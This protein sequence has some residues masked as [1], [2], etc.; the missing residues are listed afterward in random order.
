ME[1]G[2]KKIFIEH[3]TV[4]FTL[5]HQSCILVRGCKLLYTTSMGTTVVKLIIKNPINPSKKI[6]GEFLVD[7]GAHYTVLPASMVKRLGLKGAYEQK[8]F[9][10][11]GRVMKRVVA[12]ALVNFHGRELP[13]PVVLG[14][15]DDSALLGVT[16]LETFGLMLDPFKRRIYHAKL[17]LA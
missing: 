3:S 13:A 12:G 2:S 4:F 6:E 17:M 10:A 9:L 14:E 8:F 7:S 11:D 5:Y 1:K 16:T 15:K